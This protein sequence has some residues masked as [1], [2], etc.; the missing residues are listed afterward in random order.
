MCDVCH[1]ELPSPEFYEMIMWSIHIVLIYVTGMLAVLMLPLD[2][3]PFVVYMC[4]H[5]MLLCIQIV[6]YQRAVLMRPRLFLQ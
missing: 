2:S 4:T 5:I 3:K 6:L 1:E